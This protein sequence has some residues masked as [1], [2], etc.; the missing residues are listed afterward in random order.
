MSHLLSFIMLEFYHLDSMPHVISDM[1][2]R[3]LLDFPFSLFPYTISRFFTQ[4]K[5]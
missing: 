5:K 1:T 2:V 3:R 4:M